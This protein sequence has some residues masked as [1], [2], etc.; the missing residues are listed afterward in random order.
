MSTASP[1]IRHFKVLLV[2]D[3]GTGKSTFVQRFKTGDYELVRRANPTSSKETL[4]TFYPSPA[5]TPVPARV[6][7]GALPDRVDITCVDVSADSKYDG[8][9][10]QD[11]RGADAVIIMSGVSVNLSRELALTWYKDVSRVC[12]NIPAVLVANKIDLRYKWSWD[13]FARPPGM[14]NVKLMRMS[15]RSMAFVDMPW[16]YIL[17]QL[18]GYQIAFKCGRDVDEPD[19]LI[20]EPGS[21]ADNTPPAR[22]AMTRIC[23]KCGRLLDRASRSLPPLLGRRAA[24]CGACP[25]PVDV[26]GI[27]IKPHMRSLRRELMMQIE[28]A[29]DFQDAAEEE[30]LAR[31]A[32]ALADTSRPPVITT[33]AGQEARARQVAAIQAKAEERRLQRER[34][35]AERR[36]W[37]EELDR[38]PPVQEI[39]DAKG[40]YVI[41]EEC[42][43]EDEI[44]PVI[45]IDPAPLTRVRDGMVAVFMRSRYLRYRLGQVGWS[46][47]AVLDTETMRFSSVAPM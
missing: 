16:Q 8:L 7:L 28:N 17:S 37:Q 18:L 43:M 13:P 34:E 3:R 46:T 10:D 42:G 44:A 26:D 24:Y 1:A 19:E 6:P 22:T 11:Y 27:Q 20:A 35:A 5:T 33:A 36:A 21:S 47:L 15:C 40:R 25:E 31:I 12:P 39:E 38:L 9:H 23:C 30:Q 2:G 29:P 32:R 4:L 45:A 41:Y 14:E